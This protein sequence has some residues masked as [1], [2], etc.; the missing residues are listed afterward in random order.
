MED[1]K[2]YLWKSL[3][4]NMKKKILS[5][6]VKAIKRIEIYNSKK[7]KIK[8]RIMK[9]HFKIYQVLEMEMSRIFQM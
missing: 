8:L 9:L 5:K 3:R 7:D 1:L 6:Q 4:K 2:G